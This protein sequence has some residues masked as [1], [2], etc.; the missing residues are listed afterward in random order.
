MTHVLAATPHNRLEPDTIRAVFAQTYAG[1][2]DH[3]FTRHNPERIPGMN[4]VRAY[5][6]LRAVFL[7]GDYTD[8]WIVEN[9][10]IPPPNALERLLAVEADVVYGTYCFRRGTPVV[11]VMQHETTNP[12]TRDDPR[13]WERLFAAG[14]IVECAGLGFGCTVIRRHVIERFEMRTRIGGGDTDTE[15]A[16]DVKAAG[17]TQKAHL[18]VV[19]GH[20]RPTHETIWPTAEPPYYRKAGVAVPQLVTVRAVE[21]FA[22]FDEDG[23]PWAV[24]KGQLGVLDKELAANMEA[25]GQ[26]VIVGEASAP[27]PKPA[28]YLADL[29]PNLDGDAED[30]SELVTEVGA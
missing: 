14:A 19:C 5:Q 8:L 10:I 26:L 20:I 21:S 11:N 2:L 9:D 6:R 24:D 12:L 15:L 22:H 18:G 30:E 27:Q 17:L 13:R 4:I 23:L 16:R 25:R 3:H 28:G 7:A 29:P 1:S